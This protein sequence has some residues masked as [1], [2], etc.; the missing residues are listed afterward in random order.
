[1]MS[2]H[3]WRAGGSCVIRRKLYTLG[4]VEWVRD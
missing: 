2:V 4:D 1:M 3:T